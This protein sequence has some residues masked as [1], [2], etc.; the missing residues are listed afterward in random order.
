MPRNIRYPQYNWVQDSIDSTR[1][2]TEASNALREEV[3]NSE[4]GLI[5]IVELVVLV[6]LGE[7][8]GVKYN[9]ELI[10]TFN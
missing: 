8:S 6:P 7:C 3:L 2:E 10:S 1:A 4:R 5:R 9:N